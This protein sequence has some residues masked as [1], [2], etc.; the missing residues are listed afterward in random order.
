MNKTFI[1][2]VITVLLMIIGS[3]VYCKYKPKEC[4]AMKDKKV[5]DFPAEGIDW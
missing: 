2:F 5:D 4:R 1:I 3:S